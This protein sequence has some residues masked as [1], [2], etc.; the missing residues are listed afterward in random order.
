MDILRKKITYN[1][2]NIKNIS[3]RRN[4]ITYS[5]VIPIESLSNDKTIIIV[6]QP[7]S[8]LREQRHIIDALELFTNNFTL[9]E[10]V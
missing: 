6:L 8:P 1:T 9:K 4:A 5:H 2:N 3:K 10:I 7:T